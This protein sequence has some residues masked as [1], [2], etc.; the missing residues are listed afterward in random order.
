MDNHSLEDLSINTIRMLSIDAVEKAQSGHPGTPMEA[1]PMAYELWTHILRYNPANP[2][3]PNRDR[4]ILSAGHASMLLYSMLYLTGY[5]LPLEQIKQFRQ[6][7]SATPG[8]PEYGH[9][10]GVETTTGPLGQGFATGVGM[11]VA[12]K[13]LADM[14]NKPDATIVDHYIYA[15]CSDG[16]L[17]EGVSAE[18][19]SFAGHHRLNK[20]IYIYS[21]NRIT[22][23]G[24]TDLTFSESV[25]DRFKAYNWFVQHI[26]GN[27]RAAFRKAIDAAKDQKDK[28][29]MIVA[30]THIGFGSP[31]KQDKAVAH[32][33]PLGAEEVKRTKENL[34]WPLEP[35]FLV[36]DDVLQHFRKALDRGRQQEAEWQ[37]KFEEYSRK[38]P[39]EAARWKQMSSGTLP[40]GWRNALPDLSKEKGMATRAA[41]GKVM[42]A[43]ANALPNFIA[44]SADLAESTL[45]HLKDKGSF[46]KQPGGRNMHFGIREHCMGGVLNGMA[47]SGML[48]PAG[49]TFFIFSDYMRPAM[50]I[51]S[52]MKLNP[53]YVLTHDSIGLGEDGPTHQPVEHLASFRA[54]PNMT[55]LRPGDATETVAA[56]EIA[57]TRKKG[58]VCLILTR[59][60]LPVIDRTKYAPLENAKKGGY[61][62]ADAPDGKPDVILLATGSEL[63]VIMSAYEK[64]SAEG[65][66]ARVVSM[67]SWEIFEEQSADYREQVLPSGVQKRIAVEAASAFG[68]SRYVGSQ[69][70]IIA[71]KSFGASAPVEANMEG[72]GFTPENVVAKAK[73]LLGR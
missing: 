17:M 31:G 56:W 32:G 41:S 38:Y 26:D 47:L 7:G 25:G 28:P 57:V 20:L 46:G 18:A 44:G 10:S 11:A 15:Y 8:H 24:D 12:E 64:L 51:A 22:I 69:G 4:F 13:I 3:W 62:V 68:W 40:D 33:A 60:K 23:D 54:M 9:T 48:I 19:G 42:N 2:H 35:T 21:D 50:R 67:L 37:A 49:G 16:D 65:I 29:S 52:L 36:P 53:I 30:R 5:D 71:M 59:Q 73:A 63:S 1:A 43:L 14:F 6:W 39:A 45:T 72:F 61:V 70:D 58:P 55:V 27:D 34:G 66:K